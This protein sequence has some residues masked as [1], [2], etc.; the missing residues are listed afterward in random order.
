MEHHHERE[1]NADDPVV[2]AG[3]PADSF[4]EAE[5]LDAAVGDALHAVEEHEDGKDIP[6]G[7]HG[8]AYVEVFGVEFLDWRLED[9]NDGH[10][11]EG[12]GEGDVHYHI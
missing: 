10:G 9:P 12:P 8:L 11:H 1:W 7:A 5:A 2:E 4:K 3:D 6:S